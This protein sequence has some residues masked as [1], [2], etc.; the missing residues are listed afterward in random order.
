[1]PFT[2]PEKCREYDADDK[3]KLW[4]IESTPQRGVIVS[5]WDR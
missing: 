3:R 5:W 4:V 1:M 2:D